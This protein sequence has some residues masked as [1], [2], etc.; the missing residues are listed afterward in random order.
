MITPSNGTS[1]A[2][3]NRGVGTVPVTSGEEGTRV[4]PLRSEYLRNASR[5]S[6]PVMASFGGQP[7]QCTHDLDH[8]ATGIAEAQEVVAQPGGRPARVP[9]HERRQPLL[10][11]LEGPC[12]FRAGAERLPD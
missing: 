4:C 12:P 6:S 7:A 2:F 3:G 8:D 9:A 10:P 1:L 11:G 5:I